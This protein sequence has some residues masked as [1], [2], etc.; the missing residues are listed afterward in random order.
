M[1]AP[2]AEI[3]NAFFL[4]SFVL[5]PAIKTQPPEHELIQ[6]AQINL[7]AGKHRDK[8]EFKVNVGA[9]RQECFY[10]M[11]AANT[12]LHFAFEV[13]FCFQSNMSYRQTV[14]ILKTS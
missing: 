3:W 10:Q 4:A 13:R 2:V 14:Y 8:H 6:G 12:N 7:S 9:G 5:F 11:I 1:A